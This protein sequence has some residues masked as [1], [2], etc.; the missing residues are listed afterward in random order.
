L[1]QAEAGKLAP[2][3]VEMRP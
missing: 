1:K 2:I 3:E